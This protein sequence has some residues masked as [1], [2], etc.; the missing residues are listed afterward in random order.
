MLN[1]REILAA[2]E[3]R[4]GAG[5]GF[6]V[7]AACVCDLREVGVRYGSAHGEDAEAGAERM[8]RESLRPQDEVF[9]AGDEL[10]AVILPDL[11][12]RNHALLATTRLFQAFE[13]PLNPDGIPWQGRLRIGMAFFPQDGTD[14]DTLWRRTQMA[15]H[16]AA[17]SSAASAFFNEQDSRADIDYREL[18]EGIEA[19]HLRTFFQP[20]WELA[21]PRVVGVES[22]ARWNS[23]RQGAVS[24]DQFVTFAEQSDLIVA[25]THWSINATFRHAAALNGL[26]LSV[27]IN[28]SARA[29]AHGGVPEQL[30]D[31]L[32]IWGVA[33]GDVI[34]EFTE[35]ALVENLDLTVHTLNKLRD[36]GMRVAI[37]DFGT[38][39]ASLAYLGRFPATD[40]KI[41][42]T[43]IQPI[44]RD[45]RS[46]RLAES[47]IA[48]AHRLDMTVTAEG[49]ENAE[50]HRLLADMGC[51]LGQGFHLGLP[52]PAA[53]FAQQY[54][55]EMVGQ[56]LA[57]S[58]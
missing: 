20:V 55:A 34:A 23:P 4:I 1:Q 49:I 28:L 41:D 19:N 25:L 39:Y 33:P 35:T 31:A 50:T 52:Q 36:F 2:I 32:N 30:L 10:F 57:P 58:E 56:T 45:A 48:L 9:R 54:L 40:L 22:L 44:G 26:G 12:A 11:P 3:R 47:I 17:R 46:A 6:A 18:R 16:H 38:G 5:T 21:G 7:M 51:D 29:F 27:A 42:K 15:L 37:D 53:E 14:A 24:P 8:V 43:L 13:R